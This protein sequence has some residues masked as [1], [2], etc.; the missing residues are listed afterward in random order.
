VPPGVVVVASRDV[1]RTARR[2]AR[3]LGGALY[4]TADEAVQ[5]L[6]R[7]RAEALAP[8]LARVE[9]CRAAAGAA[10]QAVE[11]ARA[12][13]RPG[14][15]ALRPDDVAAA[16]R[17]VAEARAAVRAVRT[18]L[19]PRPHL[20]D[21][22][23]QRVHE[24]H[25]ALEQARRARGAR[26]PD[27]LS[28][29]TMAN[30]GAGVLVAGRLFSEAFDPA[31]FLVACLPL[32]ALGYAGSVVMRDV[33]RCRVAARRRW[34]TLRA[35][36]LCTMAALASREADVRRW[37]ERSRAAATASA[38]L[39][40]AEA[41]WSGLVGRGVSVQAAPQV[42]AALHDVAALHHVAR[43]ASAAWAEAAAALQGAEDTAGAGSAPLV[44]PDRRPGHDPQGQALAAL[45][46]AAGLA[47]VVVVR[48]AVA[49]A[50]ESPA[51]ADDRLMPAP[52]QA[53]PA[54]ALAPSGATGGEQPAPAAHRAPPV[55][56]AAASAVVDLRQRVL[57]GLLRLRTRP[58]PRDRRP[59]GS[60]ASGG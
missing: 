27:A 16:A 42:M 32:S 40:H 48:P 51:P 1:G 53:D 19:G 33:N 31:F 49:M 43:D 13:L 52:H 47:S 5:E 25:A 15:A 59:P 45:A 41:A 39:T 14:L 17:A 30:C 36:D 38:R 26:L 18:G 3:S 9:E 56:A 11:E 60:V 22:L 50:V 2:L 34:T 37:E 57:S 54:A 23:A 28:L 7:R 4:A 20:D 12:S 35:M 24:A 55:P 44:V 10:R 21:A 46:R 29:I 6:A 8:H 58:L